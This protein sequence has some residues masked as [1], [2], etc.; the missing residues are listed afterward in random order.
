[1][2][3]VSQTASSNALV[4]SAVVPCSSVSLLM[5]KAPPKVAQGEIPSAR[6]RA[7]HADAVATIL[8]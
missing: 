5:L 7:W 4:P 3:A 1:M 2:H 6:P 8:T